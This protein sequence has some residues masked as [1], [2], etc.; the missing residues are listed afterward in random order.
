MA[1]VLG[2]RL[3]GPLYKSGVRV[4]DLWLGDPADPTGADQRDIRRCY[5]LLIL[6]TLITFSFGWAVSRLIA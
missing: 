5:Q 6:S 1:G 2:L 4:C 3:I